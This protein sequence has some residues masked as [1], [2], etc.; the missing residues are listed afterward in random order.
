MKITAG[1]GSLD[2]YISFVEAGADE[3]FCGYVPSDW[4]ARFGNITPLNRREVFF[5]NV[6]IGTISDMK[7]LAKMVKKYGVPVAITFN[8]PYYLPEQYE[9]IAGY[10]RDLMALGFRDYIIADLAFLVYLKSCK[11]IVGD[12]VDST[13]GDR[14]AEISEISVRLSDENYSGNQTGIRVHLSGEFAELNRESLGLI[15]KDF[16]DIISRVIFGRKNTLADI[17]NCI[18]ESGGINTKMQRAM[19]F[20]AF[21]CNERC[22]FSGGFCSSIHSDELA[23]MCMMPYELKRKD[24]M[25]DEVTERWDEINGES[26]GFCALWKLRESGV[27]HLKIV[28]RGKCEEEMAVDIRRVKRALEILEEAEDEESFTEQVRK[29]IPEGDEDQVYWT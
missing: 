3:V 19:E 26:G 12:V 5:V 14:N 21:I 22:H 27:T 23:H 10:I 17:E 20:E 2:E 11:D 7:I 15:E 16:G 25:E 9:I 18:E 24:G 8:S 4:N 6:N 13:E 1:M 28:G 29:E